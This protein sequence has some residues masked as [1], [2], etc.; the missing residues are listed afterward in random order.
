MAAKRIQKELRDFNADPPSG[1]SAG[2]QD[3]NDI[4]K[5]QGMITGPDGSPYAG[6]VYF[7][8]IHFPTDYPFKPPKFT[9]VTRIYHPNINSNGS[10][11]VSI[12][13]EEWS[14]ALTISKVLL[15][16]S[17]LL[18]EPNPDDPLV[19]EIA[20]QLKTNKQNYEQVAREWTKKYA[21]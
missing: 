7:L 4:F 3:E 5:W 11:C 10:I 8:N 20:H 19:P 9:F 12:L 1:C 2:P 13:K 17:S 6:G 18:T 14:P 16:I 15:S 21:C